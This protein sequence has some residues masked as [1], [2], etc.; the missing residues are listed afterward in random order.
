[1]IQMVLMEHFRVSPGLANQSFCRSDI[2][3][4]QV[5]SSLKVGKKFLASDSKTVCNSRLILSKAQLIFSNGWF[6]RCIISKELTLKE[7]LEDNMLH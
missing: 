2:L 3:R 4:A 5:R 1:M 6:V 7:F